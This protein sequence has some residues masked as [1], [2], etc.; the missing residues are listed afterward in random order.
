MS[1]N[2]NMSCPTCGT[3]IDQDQQF[4]RTCGTALADEHPRG[5]RPQIVMLII[6]AV[7]FLGII[8]GI[9]GDMAGLKWLKFTGVFI[10]IA[11]MFSM[12]G[13]SIIMSM[14][15]TERV[16]RGKADQP[17]SLERADTTNKLL[18]IGDDDFIPSVVENTTELLQTTGPKSKTQQ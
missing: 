7:I 12:A 1:Y 9:S 17:R 8:A 11:G 14:P 10:S 15:K 5:I 18:P 4:C 13:A 3:S 2:K 16:K 6:F